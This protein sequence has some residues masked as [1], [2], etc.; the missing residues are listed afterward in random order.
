MITAKRIPRLPDAFFGAA[1]DVPATGAKT[2]EGDSRII[3]ITTFRYFVT[4]ML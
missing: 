1:V 2:G 4:T 3:V